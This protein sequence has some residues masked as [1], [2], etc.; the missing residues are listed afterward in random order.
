MEKF[1]EIV[2]LLKQAE[3]FVKAESEGQGAFKH[4]GFIST[5]CA[6]VFEKEAD[7]VGDD[8]FLDFAWTR[9]EDFLNALRKFLEKRQ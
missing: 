9:D 5:L 8:P 6:V 7:R 3:P 4:G 1:D 2:E